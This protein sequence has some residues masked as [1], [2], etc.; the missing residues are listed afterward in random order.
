ME[1]IKKAQEDKTTF[2][3]L[4]AVCFLV[5]LVLGFMLSP[6]KSGVTIGSNNVIASGEDD[7]DDEDDE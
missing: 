4:S 7:D 3:L 5:G 6:V 1:L 2:I